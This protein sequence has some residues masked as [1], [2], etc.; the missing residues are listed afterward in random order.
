MKRFVLG[1]MVFLGVLVPVTFL[2]AQRAD[3]LAGALDQGLP[4]IVV[5][6]EIEGDSVK[7]VPDV[8]TAKPGQRVEWVSD[9]GEWTVKFLG[10][11]PFGPG[12]A[13]P[14]IRGAKGQRNGSTA[15][16]DAPKGRYK[17][18]IMVRDG[19]RMRVRDPEVVIDPGD[20]EGL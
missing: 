16:A 12:G 19:N 9:I 7:A 1:V 10:P 15:R 3:D 20:G 5:R 8:V 18:M 13:N 6:I 14:G 11:Q 17:Y 2:P 4:T